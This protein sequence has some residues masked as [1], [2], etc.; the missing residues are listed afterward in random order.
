MAL[1]RRNEGGGPKRAANN[2]FQ[3]GP[4]VNTIRAKCRRSGGGYAS[5]A[6]RLARRSAIASGPV[7]CSPPFRRGVFAGDDGHVIHPGESLP[8]DGSSLP[9]SE[10]IATT[11]RLPRKSRVAAADRRRQTGRTARRCD[12]F[13]P[14]RFPGRS[15]SWRLGASRRAP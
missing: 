3:G 8:Q 5:D 15:S 12:G 4:T 13:C 14:A 10:P 2:D 9:V 6:A 7:G 11:G 1:R